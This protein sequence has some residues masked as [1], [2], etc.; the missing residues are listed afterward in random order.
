M[1]FKVVRDRKD[2]ASPI[3][4]RLLMGDSSVFTLELPWLDNQTNLSCIPEGVYKT[5]LAWSNR[6]QKIMPRLLNVPD[7]DGIL[8]H[9]GNTIH[10]THGCILVGMGRKPG[11]LTYS[12]VA[13]NLFFDW[14]GRA[15]REGDVFA[16]VS[17]GV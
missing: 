4:G 13:F 7:R 9:A 3:S 1:N 15:S 6:Y 10:D 11:G 2:T 8:V 12:R 14:L 5:V 16:E 17:H